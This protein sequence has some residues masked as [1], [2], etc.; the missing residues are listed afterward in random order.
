MDRKRCVNKHTPNIL[1]P[2]HM[3]KDHAKA[4]LVVLHGNL[5]IFKIAATEDTIDVWV[6]KEY[7]VADSWSKDFVINFDLWDNDLELIFSDRL[8]TR[9]L[10]DLSV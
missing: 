9:S 7:G 3:D 2:T 5:S 4:R 10:L 6:L 1:G 8:H